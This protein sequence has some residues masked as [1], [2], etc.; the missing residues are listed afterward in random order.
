[1]AKGDYALEN[2]GVAIGQEAEREAPPDLSG[3]VMLWFD[4]G[5]WA[6]AM[7]LASVLGVPISDTCQHRR[8]MS[9]R[10]M[11][12]R[13]SFLLLASGQLH[14]CAIASTAHLACLASTVGGAATSADVPPGNHERLMVLNLNKHRKPQ[15][16]YQSTRHLNHSGSTHGGE[17]VPSSA[18]CGRQHAYRPI[19]LLV[20]AKANT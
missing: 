12:T 8:Y 17:L 11:T 16:H 6:K 19:A 4:A 15:H 18:S 5:C 3:R 20:C 13:I 9:T 10:N 1:M 14:A 2:D 7:E